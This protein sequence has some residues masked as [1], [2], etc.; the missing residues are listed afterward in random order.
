M[1]RLVQEMLGHSSPTTTAIYTAWSAPD[2]AAA[3][4]ALDTRRSA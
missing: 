1:T 4:A 3:V 2:A